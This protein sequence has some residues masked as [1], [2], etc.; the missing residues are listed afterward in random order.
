MTIEQVL[1]NNVSAIVMAGLFLLYMNKRDKQFQQLMNE[2]AR[3]LEKLTKALEKIEA[4]MKKLE[5]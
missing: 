4:R 3:K 5:K 2:F 1:T